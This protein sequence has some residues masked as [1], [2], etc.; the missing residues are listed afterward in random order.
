MNDNQKPDFD[1]PRTTDG[2]AFEQYLEGAGDE[3]DAI[4]VHVDGTISVQ[5][6]LSGN[7][8]VDM[9]RSAIDLLEDYMRFRPLP[10]AVLKSDIPPRPALYDPRDEI[11]F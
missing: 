10:P 11:P 8:A 5:G 1:T 3:K 4:T 2:S 7:E 6:S 9:L